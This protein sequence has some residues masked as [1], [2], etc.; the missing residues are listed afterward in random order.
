MKKHCEVSSRFEEFWLT[1]QWLKLGKKHAARH[2]NA[3]VH[4]EQDWEEIQNARDRYAE[5]LQA[6]AWKRPQNGSTFFHNWRDWCC[7]VEPA[8]NQRKGFAIEG[9]RMN[10]QLTAEQQ[11][12]VEELRRLRQE[13]GE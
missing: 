2:F 13:R 1:G 10:E 8:R 9:S 11:R 6:N 7:W 5:H 3:S 4:T 12:G